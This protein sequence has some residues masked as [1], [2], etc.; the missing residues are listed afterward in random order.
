MYSEEKGS[1][2]ISGISITLLVKFVTFESF[3]VSTKVPIEDDP[4]SNHP[5]AGKRKIEFKLLAD[6]DLAKNF[7]HALK[8]DPDCFGRVKVSAILYCVD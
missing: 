7:L 6:N 8:T 3:D 5:Q 4:Q 2:S 1:I